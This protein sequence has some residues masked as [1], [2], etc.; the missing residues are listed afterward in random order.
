MEENSQKLREELRKTRRL[1]VILVLLVVIL[2]GVAG[3]TAVRV[4]KQGGSGEPLNKPVAIVDSR[5]NT[6]V[7]KSDKGDL[8]IKY[9]KELW[10]V[11]ETSVNP[12]GWVAH[13]VTKYERSIGDSVTV[14]FFVTRGDYL[15]YTKANAKRAG[16]SFKTD[17]EYVADEALAYEKESKRV[18][19]ETKMVVFG[20]REYFLIRS[21]YNF[22]VLGEKI[23]S[24]Q[25]AY[26]T[27]ENGATY[28]VVIGYSSLESAN[29]KKALGLLGEIKIIKS[30]EGSGNKVKGAEAVVTQPD[31]EKMVAKVIPGVVRIYSKYCAS[32]SMARVTKGSEAVRKYPFCLGGLGSGFFVD[33]SGL[34]VTNG[35]VIKVF[36]SE[37]LIYGIMSGRLDDF[38]VD[39]MMAR[40]G[41]EGA[42]AVSAV[43]EELQQVKSNQAAVY[44]VAGIIVRFI[45]A[46][47]VQFAEEPQEAYVQL[48]KKSF[49]VGR[50]FRVVVGENVMPAEVVD[51]DY[52]EMVKEG[53]IA[54]DV[55]LLKI[56][57]KNFP[58][59]K[60]GSKEAVKT[61][62]TIYVLGYP[63]IADNQYL[64]DLEDSE[65]TVTRGIISAF[66]KAAGDKRTL[67]QTDASIN[68][69]NSG[70]P[71]VN[72][73]GV[74]VGIATYGLTPEEGS[75]NFNF[76]RD[77]SDAK[78]LIERKKLAT[79]LGKT[80][81]EWSRGIDNFWMRRYA[82]AVKNFEGTK[83]LYPFHPLAD[84][85]RAEAQRRIAAGEGVSEEAKSDQSYVGW[86][87]MAVIGGF[88]GLGIVFVIIII[89]LVVR[90]HNQQKR[91]AVLENR[92]GNG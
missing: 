30:G 22:T 38:L 83:L 74:V 45:G 17:L 15:E 60:L 92:A 90:V 82:E 46:G 29:Y 41:R 26:Y 48:G 85:Y 50:D 8:E 14:S 9:D 4:M 6:E 13:L 34:I 53:F 3:L 68:H 27:V 58:A 43:R 42:E 80:S 77:V 12:T 10:K 31:E 59:L 18:I 40:S 78:T 1:I 64:V 7:L 61:G 56:T 69:G 20:D 67:L 21:G 51:M 79:N 49:N 63:G 55:A 91:L 66:K 57:G 70:G 81:D 35:H 89:F 76:L 47:E 65:I 33:E 75:G 19:K 23:F 5:D 24:P 39:L 32:L 16:K 87:L 36:P 2:G 86:L 73:E 71:A 25:D 88:L 11:S 44:Q 52:A 62:S 37:A 84:S 28:K 54:S 72:G